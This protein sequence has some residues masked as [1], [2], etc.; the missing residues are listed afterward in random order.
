MEGFDLKSMWEGADR[1]AK[2][3]YEG[4]REEVVRMAR[5]RSEDV[6][7]KIRRLF[8]L[9]LWAGIIVS[10]LLFAGLVSFLTEEGL[11]ALEWILLLLLLL[12]F[13]VAFTFTIRYFQQFNR[14][15]KAVPVH[16]IRKA[17]AE[18][19]HL[20]RIYKRN[21]IR[22]S[23]VLVPF[24]LVLGFVFGLM[25]GAEGNLSMLGEPLFWGIALGLLSI[26]G[27]LFYFFIKHYYKW[28]LGPKE[29]TLEE[30]LDSLNQ[31]D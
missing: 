2:T 6:L 9:E 13:A 11:T 3:H 27:L 20:L 25:Q 19:L 24:S 23:L 5:R 12:G 30:V 18:Y 10:V 17:T 4:L 8:W 21:L 22:L 29:K 26:A 14:R 16:D 28:M 31:D 15:A 1:Q 7:Q